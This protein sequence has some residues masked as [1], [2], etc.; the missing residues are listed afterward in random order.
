MKGNVVV[1]LIV[2][3]CLIVLV[4]GAVRRKTEWLLNMLLRAVLGMVAVYFIN[5]FLAGRGIEICV[6]INAITFLTSVIP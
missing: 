2:A 3:I 1:L 4:A 6:G 5:N